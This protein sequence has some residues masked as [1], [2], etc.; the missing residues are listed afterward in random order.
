VATEA[1]ALRITWLGHS[2]VLI[3]LDGT[4]LLTDPVLRGRVAHLRRVASRPDDETLDRVDAVLV[5]HLHHDHL[6]LPSLQ[7]L[8][9][10]VPIVAPLGAGGLLKRR[11]FRVVTETAIGDAV[12]IGA[13]EIRATPAEHEARRH[14]FGADAPAVGYVVTGTARVYFAGDTDLF[15]G[16]S[17]LAHDL[18]VALLPI[19]GW[20]PRVGRGHLDPER[21]AQALPRLRPR[22]AIPIH[23]GTYRRIGLARDEPTLR[24]P[25]ETFVRLARTVAPEVDVQLLPVGGTL[26]LAPVRRG[27]HGATR[28]RH[29]TAKL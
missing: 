12:T 26:E 25:A 7:R 24:E 11:G 28:L 23:W 27:D 5:S 10:A 29:R 13:L 20:G 2:T 8:G 21:A 3:E 22:V 1:D 15:E 19:A 9:R 18:D 16:M 4:R 14:P 6:D 17:E